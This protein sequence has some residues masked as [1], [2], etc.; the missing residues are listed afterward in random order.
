MGRGNSPAAY[1]P[2]VETT[3]VTGVVVPRGTYAAPPLA[4]GHRSLCTVKTD[5]I[6]LSH[7][8]K[9]YA[10]IAILRLPD[11]HIIFVDLLI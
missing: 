8:K 3:V 1:Q 2:Y 4:I 6:H 9:R 7:G 10:L 5:N 11:E